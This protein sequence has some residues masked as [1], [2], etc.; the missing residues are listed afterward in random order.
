M[1]DQETQNETTA[2]ARRWGT[3]AALVA[4]GMGAIEAYHS[5]HDAAAQSHYLALADRHGIGVT[6]G[7]DFHGEGTRRSEFFG[8]TNLPAA[9][10][11]ELLDRAA[12]ARA[13]VA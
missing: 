8:V 13:V 1:I 12:R 11:D 4:A 7:S 9:R 3:A 2:S 6:G 5:S 10:F